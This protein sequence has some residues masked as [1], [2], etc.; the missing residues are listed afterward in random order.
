MKGNRD[1]PTL[2]WLG[3]STLLIQ[4][5]GVN[6]LTDPHLTQRASPVSFAGAKRDTPPGLSVDDLPVIDLILI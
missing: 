6:I 5:N 4:Y 1:I 3:H 2:T